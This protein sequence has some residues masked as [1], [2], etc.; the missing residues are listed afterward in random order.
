M[1]KMSGINT[2]GKCA[3]QHSPG[4]SL[5]FENILNSKM[6]KTEVKEEEE[7]R[8]TLREGGCMKGGEGERSQLQMAPC[9][10]HNPLLF[11]KPLFMMQH[12]LQQQLLHPHLMLPHQQLP[13]QLHQQQLPQQLPQHLLPQQQ[14]LQQKLLQQHL[15]TSQQYTNN[16]NTKFQNSPELHRNKIEMRMNETKLL[17]CQ[18]NTCNSHAKHPTYLSTPLQNSTKNKLE[19]DKKE[20][21]D[22]VNVD[23]ETVTNTDPYSTKLNSLP[24]SRNENKVLNVSSTFKNN[25]KRSFKQSHEE[26]ENNTNNKDV[27]AQNSINKYSANNDSKDGS[28]DGIKPNAKQLKNYKL[29]NKIMN[30]DIEDKSKEVFCERVESLSSPP[31]IS[32]KSFRKYNKNRHQNVNPL[33]KE[34]KKHTKSIRN[35]TTNIEQSLKNSD[36]TL[37]AKS[38]IKSNKNSDNSLIPSKYPPN[39]PTNQHVDHFSG[40]FSPRK[41]STCRQKRAEANARERNRCV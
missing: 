5:N 7:K 30:Y 22:D 1:Q 16:L 20:D 11:M 24:G 10:P 34:I 36:N 32:H 29:K 12:L 15:F 18:L 28:S 21:D 9:L 26:L 39:N 8:E 14:L 37:A 31:Q 23:V 35:D 2:K 33:Q 40:T 4:D 19:V 27:C 13:Q 17:K 3:Q 41:T 25:R 6:I 38:S